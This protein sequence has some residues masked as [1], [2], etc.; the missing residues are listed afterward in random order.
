MDVPADPLYGDR[1][2]HELRMPLQARALVA[3]RRHLFHDHGVP[4]SALDGSGFVMIDLHLEAHGIPNAI[5]AE[6]ALPW[7]IVSA[8]HERAD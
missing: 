6:S 7:G 2:Y 5:V 1:A 3:A 8:V 4:R